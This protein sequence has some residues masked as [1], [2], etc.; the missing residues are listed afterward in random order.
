MNTS[1]LKAVTDNILSDSFQD[2]WAIV[3]NVLDGAWGIVNHNIIANDDTTNTQFKI[4]KNDFIAKWRTDTS[5]SV[6][7]TLPFEKI[8]N[9]SQIEVNYFDVSGTVTST[10]KYVIDSQTKNI[11]LSSGDKLIIIS[12]TTR[13][14]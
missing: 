13:R 10:D 14:I 2:A 6:A 9:T 5:G 1:W 7:I 12:G 4:I 3:V 11:T 8:E